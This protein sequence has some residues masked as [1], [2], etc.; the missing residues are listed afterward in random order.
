MNITQKTALA[1]TETKALEFAGMHDAEADKA[2]L[3]G[4]ED[5][6]KTHE[7]A[8][9][10][11]RTAVPALCNSVGELDARL[12]VISAECNEL[13]DKVETTKRRDEGFRVALDKLIAS[14]RTDVEYLRRGRQDPASNAT[15][16]ALQEHHDQLVQLR[17]VLGG[18]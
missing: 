9:S 3:R 12:G 4:R 5:K 10:F 7:Q 2:F 13:R 17:N 6:A 8:A 16:T 1:N 15:I 18:K 14:T 11:L